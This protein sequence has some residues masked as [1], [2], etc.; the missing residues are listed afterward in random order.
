MNRELISQT[1]SILKTVL[2]PDTNERS[3][4]KGNTEF[5]IYLL[6]HMISQKLHEV[7]KCDTF[8]NDVTKMG[9]GRRLQP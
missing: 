1:S 4:F 8:E 6:H 2:C 5:S 7:I 9:W 3:V